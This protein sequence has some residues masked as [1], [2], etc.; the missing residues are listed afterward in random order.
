MSNLKEKILIKKEQYETSLP[1]MIKIGDPTYF[2]EYDKLTYNRRFKGKKDWLGVVVLEKNKEIYTDMEFETL[3]LKI[4]F[5]QNE[6]HLNVYLEGKY[7]SKQK[8]KITEIGVD[9]A[10]YLLETTHCYELVNTMADGYW[11]NVI[12]LK[13]GSKLEGIMI[14]LGIPDETYSFEDI[15]KILQNLFPKKQ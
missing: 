13:N 7:F 12:E 6:Q 15:L 14:D 10:E 3:S 2:G 1:S 9:T 5:A 4:Y 8:I 11:G